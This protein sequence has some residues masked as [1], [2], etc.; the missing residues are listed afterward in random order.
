MLWTVENILDKEISL[1]ATRFNK[2]VVETME[3]W[4]VSNSNLTY[5][6]AKK[7]RHSDLDTAREFALGSLQYVVDAKNR[8]NRP[9]PDKI[10]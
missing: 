9:C 3:N 4:F 7:Q 1:E 6:Q 2:E 8:L 5:K 10:R